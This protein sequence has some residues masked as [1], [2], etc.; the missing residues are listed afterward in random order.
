MCWHQIDGPN[1]LLIKV[2][3]LA[4]CVQ[5]LSVIK[6]HLKIRI[7]HKMFDLITNYSSDGPLSYT[8]DPLSDESM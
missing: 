5:H 1:E 6:G 3:S 7:M 8:L 2:S 4:E